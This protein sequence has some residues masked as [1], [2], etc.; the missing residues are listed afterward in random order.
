MPLR[1]KMSE[2]KGRSDGE[3]PNQDS[4]IKPKDYKVINNYVYNPI[5]KPQ[6]YKLSPISFQYADYNLPILDLIASIMRKQRQRQ[7]FIL[8]NLIIH[9]VDQRQAAES[10]SQRLGR[11]ITKEMRQLTDKLLNAQADYKGMTGNY[12]Y[13][14][15]AEEAE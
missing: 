15:T 8:E 11:G 7:L 2:K 3:K 1:N 9:L 10:R 5:I 6:D 13:P 12:F 14:K 4:L